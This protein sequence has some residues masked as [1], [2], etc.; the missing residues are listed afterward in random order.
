[1]KKKIDEMVIANLPV[2]PLQNN[3]L[4]NDIC[5]SNFHPMETILFCFLLNIGRLLKL[6]EVHPNSFMFFMCFIQFSMFFG[7]P[8]NGRRTVLRGSK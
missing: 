4:K 7:G 2:L 1:M 6:G 8:S 3:R 5:L